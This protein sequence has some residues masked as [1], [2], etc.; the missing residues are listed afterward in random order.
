[1]NRPSKRHC[2]LYVFV[3]TTIF[4]PTFFSFTTKEQLNDASNRISGH[5][6]KFYRNDPRWRYYSANSPE[7]LPGTVINEIYAAALIWDQALSNFKY[8]QAREAQP[9][10]T[11]GGG[12]SAEPADVSIRWDNIDRYGQTTLDARA[13]GEDT[14]IYSAII[15][16]RNVQAYWALQCDEDDGNIDLRTVAAHEFGHGAGLNDSD[17]SSDVMYHWY[18]DY[19]CY[20]TLQTRDK[21]ALIALYGAKSPSPQLSLGSDTKHIG[22]SKRERI[23][24]FGDG[25]LWKEQIGYLDFYYAHD[26]ELKWIFEDHPELY[27]QM[28]NVASIFARD[29]FDFIA[30]DG[31]LNNVSSSAGVHCALTK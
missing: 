21:N 30:D 27:L 11:C 18:Y 22:E 9:G 5:P 4:S 24:S 26:L 2:L 10:G 6:P 25:Q 15:R 29:N 14:T 19:T 16:L 28:W 31:E 23:I 12:T 1:M 3:V 8:Y 13:V 7:G 20:R 17:Y